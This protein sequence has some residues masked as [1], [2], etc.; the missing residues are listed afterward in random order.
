M[1]ILSYNVFGKIDVDELIPSWNTRI[2][3]LYKIINDILKDGDIKV[4]CFQEVNEN[5]IELITKICNK[6]DFKILEKFAM[7]TR[8]IY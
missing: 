3:N 8:T 4:I 1:K 5:N 7:K 6:N 2:E